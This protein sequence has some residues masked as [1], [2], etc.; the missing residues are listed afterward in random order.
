[1]TERVTLKHTDG[2]VVTHIANTHSGND[3]AT[4]CGLATDGDENSCE[5]VASPSRR[6]ISCHDCYGIWSDCREA[7]MLHFAP[8]ART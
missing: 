2:D 6:R 7:C 5:V 1:M 4:I 8:E 3:Y